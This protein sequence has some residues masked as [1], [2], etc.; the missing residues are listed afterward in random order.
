MLSAIALRCKPQVQKFLAGC[1]REPTVRHVAQHGNTP[2]PKAHAALEKLDSAGLGSS[3][4]RDHR[5]PGIGHPPSGGSRV[6]TR[7]IPPSEN[8]YQKFGIW[9][10]KAFSC[11]REALCATVTPGAVDAEPVTLPGICQSG[12]KPSSVWEQ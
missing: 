2:S 12:E 4:R 9:V 8:L 11:D 1:D 7:C 6:E 3:Y 5:D 10:T